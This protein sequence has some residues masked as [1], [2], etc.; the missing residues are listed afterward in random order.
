MVRET[1]TD[2]F[3]D[4]GIQIIQFKSRAHRSGL[5]A[6]LLAATVPKEESGL[7]ADFGAGTGAVGMAAAH[8]CRNIQADLFEIDPETVELAVRSLKLPQNRHLVGRVHPHCANIANSAELLSRAEREANSYNHILINPPFNDANYRRS[9]QTSKAQAHM[10]SPQDPEIWIKTAS[11]LCAE[12]G[13]LTLIIRPENLSTFIEP[14]QKRFGAIRLLP[15]HAKAND[16]ASRLLIGATRGSKTPLRIL[17]PL[18]IHE[19]N[20]AF[21]AKV[22]EILRGRAGIDLHG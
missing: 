9:P 1:T 7:V 6:I 3:L 18:F 21:T 8:R 11:R 20:G 10:F 5:D 19:E 13:R 22:E 2:G 12:K 15:V 16:T 17:P 4:N 14:I